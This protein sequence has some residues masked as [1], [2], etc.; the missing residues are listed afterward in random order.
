MAV[1]PGC[2]GQCQHMP[3]RRR[4]RLSASRRHFNRPEAIL[5]N[6]FGPDWIRSRRRETGTSYVKSSSS[7]LGAATHSLLR[8]VGVLC[9]GEGALGKHMPA[10]QSHHSPNTR[11][12]LTK[13]RLKS[14][15]VLVDVDALSKGGWGLGHGVGLLF[16]FFVCVC[17]GVKRKQPQQQQQQQ[18]QWQIKK[19]LTRTRVPPLPHQNSPFGTKLPSGRCVGVIISAV[20][21]KYVRICIQ[22]HKHPF[23]GSSSRGSLAKRTMGAFSRKDYELSRVNSWFLFSLKK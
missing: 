10:P 18:Q 13:R 4:R 16:S 8:R 6:V 23:F 17:W 14:L 2:Q 7:G 1:I 12:S 20:Q 21:N 15:T 3:A 9:G 19:H 5:I 11:R 22:T